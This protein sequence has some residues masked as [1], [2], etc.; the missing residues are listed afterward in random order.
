MPSPAGG[1][2]LPNV[3]DWDQ[4]Q[5]LAAEKEILGFFITGHPLDKYRDKL[6]DFHALT[7][8]DLCS[9]KR[10][11]GKDELLTGGIISGLRIAKSKRGDMYAQAT[12]EDTTGAI[13]LFVFSKDFKRLAEKV[14]VEVP[15][16]VRGSIMVEEGASPKL[17]ATEIT[18]LDQ[19]QPKLPRSIRIKI[20]A[21]STTDAAIDALHAIFTE[22]RG[23]AK[24]LFDVEREGD[25]VAVME[26]E[27]YNVQADRSFIARVEQLFGRG[28]VRIVD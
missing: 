27:G 24:V 21:H 15:V 2:E 26:A 18:P 25:F 28:S 4:Q 8:E 6:G 13:S 17:S 16:L 23:M 22:S 11:T 14:K 3:P 5:Q 10:G 12:L 9:L 7:I 1:E 20:P 19:A